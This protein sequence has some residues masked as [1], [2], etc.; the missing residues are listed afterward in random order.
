MSPQGDLPLLAGAEEEDL[1]EE[2]YQRLRRV[3]GRVCPAWMA[4]RGDDLVQVAFM[5]V[6]DLQRRSEGERHFSSSYLW[7]VAYSALVDEI[8]RLH[9]RQEVP[10]E[11]DD[12]LAFAPAAKHPSPEE[13]ATGRQIATGVRQCLGGLTEG[14]RQAV[15]LYLVGHT[16]PEAAALL[17]W[18][19]KKTENLVYRG[20]NDLRRCLASKGLEP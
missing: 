3:I 17:S 10:L 1:L 8:R 14:R 11:A 13:D 19:A 20:L 6:M 4:D 18:S 2:L 9:R 5:R 16:V 12:G 7:K 15:T